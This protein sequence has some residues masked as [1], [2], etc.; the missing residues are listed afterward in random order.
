MSISAL[1]KQTVDKAYPTVTHGKGVFLYDT[2][3]RRYLDGSSGP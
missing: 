1:L 3:G 2:E